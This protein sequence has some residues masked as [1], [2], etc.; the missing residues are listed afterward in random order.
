MEQIEYLIRS[1]STSEFDTF[2]SQ[3]SAPEISLGGIS[4][5][6]YNQRQAAIG[7]KIAG[8]LYQLALRLNDLKEFRK[9]MNFFGISSAYCDR[10]CQKIAEFKAHKQSHGRLNDNFFVRNV[11][12]FFSRWQNRWV[13]LT[14]TS[15]AYYGS[16]HDRAEKVKDSVIFDV[17]TTV[18]VADFGEKGLVVDL[19]MSRRTLRLLVESPL[20]GVLALHYISKIFRTNPYTKLHIHG[21][22]APSR[23]GNAC[24]LFNAGQEYFQNIFNCIEQ[25]RESI[26]ITDWWFSPEFPLLRPAQA[27]LFD[28]HS[29]IDRTLGRAASRGVKVYVIVYKEFAM[30]MSNDSEHVKST[31]EALGPNV[32]VLRHPNVIASLWSHHEKMCIVDRHTVFLGGLDLCWGRWDSHDHQLFD[33]SE[34]MF[35]AV[36]YYNPLKKDIA[37]G[38]QFQKSMIER[39]YP[40]MPWNDIGACVRGPVVADY[41]VHFTAYW[42][43]ARET[44]GEAEVM[45]AQKTT[46]TALRGIRTNSQENAELDFDPYETGN[47]SLDR[48]HPIG[49]SGTGNQSAVFTS[50]VELFQM[51]NSEPST[52]NGQYKPIFLAKL[53]Q[54]WDSQFA[55]SEK[56]RGD[57]TMLY[58]ISN[59]YFGHPDVSNLYAMTP[60]GCID[61]RG[62]NY[63]G[64]IQPQGF[65]QTSQYQ[66]PGNYQQA[67][68]S[69]GFHSFVPPEGLQMDEFQRSIAVTS[70]GQTSLN[71]GYS[72]TQAGYGQPNFIQLTQQVPAHNQAINSDNKTFSLISNNAEDNEPPL[73]TT[74]LGIVK[75]DNESA[76]FIGT[77]I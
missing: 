66:M 33:D 56:L 44:N 60:G 75:Q 52:N 10:P 14:P 7:H 48:I 70:Q 24:Q 64:P 9:L 53:K 35:P 37:Q 47:G 42:N 22:F 26:M 73:G 2:R 65:N 59:Q 67:Q 19:D 20:E 1:I 15:V 27:H 13:M 57:G 40:R 6:S 62:Q 41:V 36:D 12:R 45:F 69:S 50:Q 71:F 18:S 16:P 23:L 49:D 55:A 39:S 63:Q 11:K 34:N 30:S 76:F 31:L 32:K 43:H 51:L 68:N 74:R 17:D 5:Q 54:E 61:P 28:E 46:H 4:D 21:A 38:R 29:R 72:T 8:Y 77:L 25:A 58:S 3:C